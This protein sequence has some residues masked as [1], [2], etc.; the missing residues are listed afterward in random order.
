MN[1]FD[2]VVVTLLVAS[3]GVGWWRGLTAELFSLLSWAGAIGVG[4]LW[5]QSV[6]E[7]LLG[8]YLANPQLRWLGGAALLAVVIFLALGIVQPLIQQ[9]LRWVELSPV[10]RFFGAWFALA[11]AMVLVGL[12]SQVLLWLGAD[13]T[14]WWQNAKTRPLIEG[15]L[16]EVYQGL[17]GGNQ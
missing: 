16:V 1:P 10:D 8:A 11:R 2:V 15:L 17:A 7:V 6:G 14:A 5:G 4:W 12:G 9:L 13:R 3:M